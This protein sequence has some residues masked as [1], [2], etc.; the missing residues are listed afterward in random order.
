MHN[1]RAEKQSVMLFLIHTKKLGR[2]FVE[3]SMVAKQE[4]VIQNL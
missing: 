3:I 1:H 4:K 2:K